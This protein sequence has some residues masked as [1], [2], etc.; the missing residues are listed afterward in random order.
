MVAVNTDA[1]VIAKGMIRELNAATGND[2]DGVSK[3]RDGY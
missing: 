3:P 2:A 1:A